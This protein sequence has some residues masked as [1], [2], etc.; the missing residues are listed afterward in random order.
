MAPSSLP[1][2]E[3]DIPHTDE[4]GG[5]A[6]RYHAPAPH[7][8]PARIAHLSVAEAGSAF[9]TEYPAERAVLAADAI[10]VSLA[11]AHDRVTAPLARAAV[12]F[13]RTSA[14]SFFGYA[15]LD[16]HARERFGRCGRSLRDLAALGDAMTRLPRLERALDGDDGNRP[17]DRSAAVLVARVAR[18]DTI[19]HWIDQARVLTVRELRDAIRQAR[20]GDR[21]AHGDDIRECDTS[22][23][24]ARGPGGTID[25]TGTSRFG[26]HLEDE[27][28]TPRRLIKF[29]VPAAT[30]GIFEEALELYRAVEG[31]EA[32]V[33]SFIEALV[34]EGMTGP[35]P[36]SA[37]WEVESASLTQ[38][39]S[40][41]A[42]ERAH[43]RSTGNWR[44]LPRAGRSD[45]ALKMAG[46][47]LR[48]FAA[49]CEC[50]G[51][52]DAIELDR[53]IRELQRIEDEM[54]RRLAELLATMADQGAWARLRFDGSG[55]YA[56]ERLRISRSVAADR[57]R[58][59][60]GL[61]RLPVIR[62][63]YERGE[64][65][66]E[67]TLH[68]IRILRDA[69]PDEQMQRLWVERAR[70]ATVKRMRDEAR[71]IERRRLSGPWEEAD[72]P[73]I[74]ESVDG[75]SMNRGPVPDAMGNQAGV[76]AALVNHAP[77]SDAAWRGSLLREP[78][79]TRDR[80]E[81]LG[82]LTVSHP[83]PD[84]FL[85]LRLT[86]DVAGALL[87]SIESRRR[88]MASHV[89]QIP[90]DQPWP[91]AGAP[92][93]VRL[94]REFFVR[95]RR[96][97]AWV[98]LLSLLEE[99]VLTWDPPAEEVRRRSDA[100]YARAGWR[101]CAPGCTSRRNLENHHLVHRS[102]GGGDELWNRECL[103]RFHHQMG[104]HGT[105]AR[106][107][108]RAPLGVSW[109]I[110]RDRAATWWLNEIRS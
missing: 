70:A 53:Q 44:L 14:W 34:A 27:A 26:P 7:Q 66:L 38:S 88:Y 90:W 68:I 2:M 72:G 13:V 5:T 15:R 85:R 29:L 92:A 93:S 28:A 76:I 78:G 97:P 6:V 73:V 51:T 47:S 35:C 31:C 87:S 39:D 65:T 62:Q 9:R 37:D 91:D 18:A 16:D 63:S 109:R 108:G 107:R 45:W 48:E 77:L 89:E 36:S 101:C 3:C 20:E 57:I 83:V 69:L 86:D 52:G 19:D 10:A 54:E 100:V 82:R 67:P 12:S 22:S 1:A 56:E 96:T 40:R 103:C 75:E 95:C 46:A 110:G 41:D 71:E 43:E 32:T 24:D 102:S 79:T 99:F 21:V 64:I 81:R 25:R 8:P 61:R 84:V 11:A 80:V 74:G 58:A 50:A 105:L 98:G 94:A 4:R 104:E 49:L 30:M 33:T 23:D 60:R 17:L 55:H 106:C 59:A 42:I